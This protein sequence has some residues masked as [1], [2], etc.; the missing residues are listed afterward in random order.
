MRETMAMTMRAAVP[1]GDLVDF[2]VPEQVGKWAFLF[3][4]LFTIA[5][6]ARPE[7]IVPPLGQLHLTF[8]FGCCSGVA[9]LGAVVYRRMR[10][11]WTQEL[12]LTLLLTALYIVGIPFAFWRS[13]S[14][15]IVT[16]VWLKTLFVFFLLTQTLLTLKRIRWLLWAIILSELALTGFSIIQSSILTW[17]G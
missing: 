11:I 1:K 8:I 16:H 6:Y 15:H 4:W 2:T 3:L 12:K 7:D 14:F 5:V 10:F 9:Y 17:V 13:A